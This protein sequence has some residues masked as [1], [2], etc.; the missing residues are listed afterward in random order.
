MKIWC[1]E[2]HCEHDLP[3]IIGSMSRELTAAVIHQFKGWNLKTGHLCGF[4]EILMVDML[5][6]V[7]VH[8]D[9]AK[10]MERLNDILT[11]MPARVHKTLSEMHKD[12][13]LMDGI[14]DIGEAHDEQP[15]EGSIH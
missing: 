9:E 7:L 3:Q 13:T 8:Y 4:L 12:G 2:C 1:D 15:E 10:R 5:R 14:H 11:K 6:I